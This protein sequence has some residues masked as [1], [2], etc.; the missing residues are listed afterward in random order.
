LKTDVNLGKE[1]VEGQKTFV[2]RMPKAKTGVTFNKLFGKKIK[3]VKAYMRTVRDTTIS[4]MKN[5]QKSLKGYYR[6]TK[7]LNRHKIKSKQLWQKI[8]KTK[9]NFAKYYECN[10]SPSQI[11]SRLKKNN[12]ALKLFLR[13]WNKFIKTYFIEKKIDRVNWYKAGK[14]IGGISSIIIKPI[15]IKKF[16]RMTM[17]NWKSKYFK[18]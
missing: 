17:K 14:A 16:K 3:T 4:I 2:N 9:F 15:C 12:R 13:I 1:V 8:L 7:E 5:A 18:K 6:C 11:Y 10:A